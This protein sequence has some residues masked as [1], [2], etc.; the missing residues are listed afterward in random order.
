MGETCS[1]HGSYEKCIENKD[2]KPESNKLRRRTK[3]RWE[4][5]IK[6]D[7]QERECDCGVDSSG[8]E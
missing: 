3:S 5:N 6:N 8:S 1:T 2:G 7:L 4:D